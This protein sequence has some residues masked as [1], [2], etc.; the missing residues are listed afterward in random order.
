[1]KYI[2]IIALFASILLSEESNE[3]IYKLKSITIKQSDCISDNKNKLCL[4]KELTYPKTDIFKDTL[5]NPLNIYIQEAKDNF[6]KETLKSYDITIDDL[7]VLLESPDY[8]TSTELKLFDYNTPILSLENH[9]YTYLGGAHGN[10]GIKYINYNVESKKELSLNDLVDFNNSKFLNIAEI[11]YRKSENILPSESLINYGWFENKFQLAN[12]FAITQDGILF[13]YDPY[14]IKAYSAGM[15]TFLLRYDKIINY[16]RPNTPLIDIAQNYHPDISKEFSSELNNGKVKITINDNRSYLLI[17]VNVEIY[18][19]NSERWL[20]LS[21]P[22]LSADSIT[23]VS[24]KGVNSFKIYPN[25][26]KIYNKKSKRIMR[27]KYPLVEAT[28][29]D[30]QYS[31]SIKIKKASHLPYICMNYRVT[32]KKLNL[33]KDI[34]YFDFKDQQGFN[35]KR[36]C[37]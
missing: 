17:K 23:K 3:P 12:N 34:Y 35:V 16:L 36:V 21:F 4:N 9:L 26:S 29:K 13:S 28:S 6:E 32:T 1:M 10:Y 33:L 24:S 11:E 27:A 30:N 18:D 8:E 37:Y 15:T 5:L 2:I 22:E 20:S 19:K 14:E 7:D 25:S 31:L